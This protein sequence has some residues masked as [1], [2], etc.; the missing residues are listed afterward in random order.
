MGNNCNR[1]LPDTTNLC[2]VSLG[3]QTPE[4]MPGFCA[5][6]TPRGDTYREEYCRLMSTAGEWQDPEQFDNKC[7][8]NDCVPYQDVGFGCCGACCGILGAG[9]LCRRARF[10]G[11]PATCCFNDLACAGVTAGANPPQCYS[12]PEKQNACSDGQNGQPNYRSIVSTSCQDYFT[13]FCTGTLRDDDPN[14]TEW[15]DRWTVN[16]GGT[17]S[18]AFA[19][20]RNIFQVG[21]TGHC[22]PP[23]PPIPG[24][25]NIP[26]FAPLDSEG[27]FWAQ[28]LVSAAMVR[29]TDQG[30]E[31]GSLPGFPGYNPFQDFLYNNVCCPYPGLCQDGLETICADK[32]AQ[33]ISLNPAVA[34]WCGCHLPEGEYQ[35]YS[36]RF[37]IPPECTP[38]CNRVGTIPIVGINAEPIRCTQNICLIDGVTLNLINSQI[39]GGIDFNQICGNCQGAQCSCIVSNTT[40]DISNSSIGGNVIP[41][42]EGCGSLTCSQTNPGTT[43]PVNI[44]VPCGSTAG[45]NPFAQFEAEQAAAEAAAKKNA[46]LWTLI[47]I[48]IALLLIFLIIAFV[49][50]NI[51]PSD[52]VIVQTPRPSGQSR[53][54][55]RLPPPIPVTITHPT[56]SVTPI[57]I[58]HPIPITVTNSRP[59]I[60]NPRPPA[61][62]PQP[63]LSVPVTNPSI[64]R[65]ISS[66]PSSNIRTQSQNNTFARHSPNFV[67]IESR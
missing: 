52:A 5:I 13:Q 8:F 17:G 63:S 10:T 3:E 33:R 11:D 28:R 66:G 4:P 48:G 24:I 46:W 27:Y 42:S 14:S 9:L 59:P 15:L 57:A 49:Q 23:P 51:Y 45:F 25:C 12:D 50:P 31:I 60:G 26:P 55:P 47:A 19:I 37:N 58:T 61:N 40:V 34:Q 21:G 2:D 1:P 35:D 20:A 6:A 32:T 43:G 36:V 44:T 39:G 18:C 64:N 16:G 41:V 65:P 56:T 22:F 54:L 38:M 29:Y 62:N 7:S 53:P 30:F 67:S